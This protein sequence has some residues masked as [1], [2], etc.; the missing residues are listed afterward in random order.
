MFYEDRRTPAERDRDLKERE[1]R[2]QRSVLA[3]AFLENLRRR[4]AGDG[5][6]EVG[7]VGKGP[8]GVADLLLE[9][10]GVTYKLSAIVERD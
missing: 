6:I 7:L 10:D 3:V 8:S 9:V 2:D 4:L 1:K 5:S